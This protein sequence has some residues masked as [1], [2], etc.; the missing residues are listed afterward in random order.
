[1][2]TLLDGSRPTP[3]AMAEFTPTASACGVVCGFGEVGRIAAKLLES[4]AQTG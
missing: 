4:V 3:S 2:Y 1:M